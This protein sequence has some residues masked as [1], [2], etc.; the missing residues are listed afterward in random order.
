MEANACTKKSLMNSYERLKNK[1]LR[2]E[3][4]AVLSDKLVEKFERTEN[5]PKKGSSNEGKT[6]ISNQSD[7]IDLFN[8]INDELDILLNRIG[9]N[10]DKVIN[11]ID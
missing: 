1:A 3:E 5:M 9:S 2:F 4:L 6:L 7:I 8:G 11:M 10:V